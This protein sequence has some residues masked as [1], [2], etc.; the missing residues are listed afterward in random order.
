MHLREVTPKD[1]YY[2][3]ILRQS[4]KS[5]VLL[6]ER[7]VL[8][9]EALDAITASQFRQL[10]QWA[11]ENLLEDRLLSV[12]NWLEISFHL[13]KQRWDSSIDWLETQPMSKIFTMIEIVK[14]HGEEQEREM[15]KASRKKR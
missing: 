2:V 11:S 9:S 3:Q 1:L 7:L 12:E 13:C 4:D 8:N 10:T 5:F 6:L 15:K 14:K